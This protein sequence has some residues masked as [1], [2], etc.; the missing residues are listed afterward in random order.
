MI[1]I[2]CVDGYSNELVNK[3]G[4]NLPYEQELSI[5]KACYLGGYPFTPD[6]WGSMFT[7]KIFNHPD[8][9]IKYNS[10]MRL[11]LRIRELFH[12][13]GIK[14]RRYGNEIILDREKAVQAKEDAEHT[15]R[16][17]KKS[18]E[19]SVFDEYKNPFKYNIPSICDTF[20][21]GGPETANEI[22]KVFKILALSLPRYNFDIAALY[23][24]LIDLKGH[25]TLKRD[26]MKLKSDY[27]DIYELAHYNM[28]LGNDTI[29]VSDHSCIEEHGDTAYFG[30]NF[31]VDIESILD[32]AELLESKALS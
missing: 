23:T 12:S 14:W 15:Y 1:M 8:R 11:R 20:Y 7:G 26:Y 32:I 6:V 28:D 2:L 9:K 4:F 16:H 3:F 5:P 13:L 30:A 22:H 29:V 31:S 18:I 27:M 25:Y 10:P 19:K 24:P 17:F 21:F